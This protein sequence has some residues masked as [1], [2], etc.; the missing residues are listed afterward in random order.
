[1][2]SLFDPQS[3]RIF[4]SFRLKM[5]LAIFLTAVTQPPHALAF[6][7]WLSILALATCIQAFFRRIKFKGDEFCSWDEALWLI[8]FANLFRF[9]YRLYGS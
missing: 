9:S 5:A 4:A 3:R 8:F 6:A 7:T 2:L 1:M